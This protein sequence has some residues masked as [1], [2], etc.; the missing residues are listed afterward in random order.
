M[1]NVT[2][3]KQAPTQTTQAS[4]AADKLLSTEG[5][6]DLLALADQGQ[7]KNK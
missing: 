5:V 2:P 1:S 7:N 4:A 3:V 6:K